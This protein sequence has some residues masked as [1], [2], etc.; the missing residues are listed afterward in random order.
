MLSIQICRFHGPR[1][2]ADPCH[3]QA[4]NSRCW[5]TIRPKSN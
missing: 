4:A 5:W 2:P 3:V 1:S